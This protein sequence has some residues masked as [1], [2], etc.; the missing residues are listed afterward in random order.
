[1]LHVPM[2]LEWKMYPKLRIMALIKV[3]ALVQPAVPDTTC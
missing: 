2:L 3:Q 1:M